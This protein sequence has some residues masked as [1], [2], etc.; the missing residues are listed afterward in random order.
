MAS[1]VGHTLMGSIIGLSFGQQWK[2]LVFLAFSA[3]APDL[4]FIPGL[5][6]GDVRIFH[7]GVTHSLGG[8]VA[9]GSFVV[10]VCSILRLE[11]RSLWAGTGFLAY[12]S[13]LFLDYVVMDPSFPFGAQFLWPFSH[14]Y[15]MAPFAFWPRFDY[16]DT[17][18]EMLPALF[19]LNNV[20][21]FLFEFIVLLPAVLV[22]Y[23]KKKKSGN[24]R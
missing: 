11:S 5:L 20:K 23:L 19:S 7:H 8:T 13:H 22:L 21:T 24:W 2:L 9:Y 4:D 15:Y 18:G 12:L 10:A 3:N 14:S 17:K 1:P 6:L 16:L